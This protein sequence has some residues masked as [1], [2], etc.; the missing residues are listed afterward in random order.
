MICSIYKSSKKNDTYLYVVKKDQF[1]SVPSPLMDSFGV[2]IFVLTMSLTNKQKLALA[3]TNKVL[4]ELESK[5]FYLQLPPPE[6]NL[7]KQHLE[8]K[9]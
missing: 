6:E 3:D 7:L 9:Q 8:R 2:P 1:D 5:G 4:A